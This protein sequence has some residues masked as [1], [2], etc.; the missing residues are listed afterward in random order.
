MGEKMGKKDKARAQKQK[1][2]KQANAA[3]KKQ[4]KQKPRTP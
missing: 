3:K 4:D 2:A 1:D